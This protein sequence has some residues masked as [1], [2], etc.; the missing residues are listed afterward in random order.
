MAQ[1]WKQTTKSTLWA[2]GLTVLL[3]AVLVAPVWALDPDRYSAM[4]AMV[5]AF[6]VTVAAGI[7][8]ATIRSNRHDR[9]TDRVLEIHRE[10]TEGPTNEARVR[11]AEHLRRTASEGNILLQTTPD[12]LKDPELEV[13][14]YAQPSTSS[15]RHDLSLLVRLFERAEA[16]REA[17]TVDE[18]LFTKLIGGHAG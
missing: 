9:R 2:L 6:S 3:A 15:P 10:L 11:L 1:P 7:A 13:S 8:I 16:A 5:Q 12:Q 17:R 4:G 18:R 14:A